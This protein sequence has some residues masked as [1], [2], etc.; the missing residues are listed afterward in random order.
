[1]E[2]NQ[3]EFVEIDLK[4]LI[5]YLLR[6]WRTLILAAICG[7]VLLGCLGAVRKLRSLGN[8]E[9][10][11][12]AQSDY[13]T[14]TEQYE[15]SKK[16]LKNQVD[17]IQQEIENQQ[18]YKNSSLLMNID[19]YNEYQA[20]A[21]Y[22]IATDYQIQPGMFY[23]NVNPAGSILNAYQS[24]AENGGFYDD[25]SD[26]IGSQ[27]KLK[28]S[29]RDL[30]ELVT[31]TPDYDNFMMT[32]Q[33]V[34]GTEDMAESIMDAIQ[35]A[36]ELKTDEIAATMGKHSLNLIANT[37]EIAVDTKLA[38]KQTKYEDNMNTLQTS[39]ADKQKALTELKK[40]EDTRINRR[41]VLK[42]SVKYSILGFFLGG[43]VIVLG[44]S[45]VYVMQ[46]RLWDAETLKRRWNMPVAAVLRRRYVGKGFH[47]IDRLIDKLQGITDKN[48]DEDNFY[49]LTAGLLRP[50]MAGINEMALVGDVSDALLEQVK[51]GLQ[52]VMPDCHI[53]AVGDI[54]GDATALFNVAEA[55]S[56]LV[57]ADGE[58]TTN[59]SLAKI[60]DY[61]RHYDKKILGVLIIR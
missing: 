24:V 10:V 50:M 47:C 40:P 37:A 33:A 55:K 11:A 58:N 26:E 60:V 25:L 31:V 7:M 48:T 22:Y 27:L 17:N 41:S 23:Q 9:A 36:M 35:E 1:M 16:L 5:L 2:M 43:F 45:S 54:A 34:G 42:G 28:V 18:D 57:V 61:S 13:E 38:E 30:K 32:I 46:D 29:V 4:D 39:I 19:P 20:T 49:Q 15:I 14:A 12:E 56:V 53:A 8:A 3:N 44:L 51:V 52:S 21:V 6:R 59:S